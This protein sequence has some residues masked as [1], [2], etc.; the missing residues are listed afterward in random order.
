MR[1]GKSGALAVVAGVLAL[2]VTASGVPI[3]RTSPMVNIPA[4]EYVPF[5][6]ES[7]GKGKAR[8]ENVPLRMKAF[9]L[10]ALPVTNAQYLDFVREHS[11]WRR[12]RIKPL[13]ADQ[14]YLAHWRGDLELGDNAAVLAPV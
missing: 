7:P 13:F 10:D 12:S 6:Q 14:N 5:F 2:S 8:V 1:I 4:G 11:E 9:R 3:L